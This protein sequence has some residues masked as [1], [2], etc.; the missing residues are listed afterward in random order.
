MDKEGDIMATLDSKI[1]PVIVYLV[2][3]QVDYGNEYRTFNRLFWHKGQAET[4]KKKRNG[5]LI[6]YIR[7]A[8][9]G[10]TDAR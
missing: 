1:T 4:F 7:E 10:D 8:T 5:Q 6:R 3:Y 2:R 9:G